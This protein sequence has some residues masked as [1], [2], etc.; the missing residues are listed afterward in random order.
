MSVRG[1][2]AIVI[3]VLAVT[4]AIGGGV[5]VAGGDAASDR[6]AF[7]DDVAKRLGV[8]PAQLKAA[9]AGAYGDR[10]DAAVAAGKITKEQADVMKQRA[11]DGAPPLFGGHHFGGPGG[12]GEHHGGGLFMSLDAAATYLGVTEAQLHTELE[13]GKSLAEVAKAEGKS[14]DGLKKALAAE[15]KKKLDA[16]VKDGRLTQAQADELETRLNEHLDGVLNGTGRLG[17]PHDGHGWGTPPPMG[18][19]PPAAYLPVPSSAATA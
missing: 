18:S 14:V 3:G 1:K 16:A 5:A 12:P 19:A 13:S 7:L 9:L 15:G 8:T 11:K 6:Q 10:L 2:Q 4:L 17:G